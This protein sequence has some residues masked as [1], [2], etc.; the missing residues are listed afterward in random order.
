MA[1]ES[2]ERELRHTLEVAHDNNEKLRAENARL[3]AALEEMLDANDA[4]QSYGCQALVNVAERHAR[5][6]LEVRP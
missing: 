2:I 4:K 3:R 6:A 5:E 1:L